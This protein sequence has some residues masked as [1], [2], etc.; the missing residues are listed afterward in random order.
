MHFDRI[1]EHSCIKVDVLVLEKSL[2]SP[3][4]INL[5]VSQLRASYYFRNLQAVQARVRNCLKGEN[6]IYSNNSVGCS[7]GEILE[8]FLIE[9]F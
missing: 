1:F 5:K 7:T 9:V 4:L 8:Y 6:E 3:M 2:H